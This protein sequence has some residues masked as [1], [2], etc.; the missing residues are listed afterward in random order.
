M[1]EHPDG[2]WGQVADM[3]SQQIGDLFLKVFLRQGA[4]KEASNSRG[5]F[6]VG[7]NLLEKGRPFAVKIPQLFHCQQLQDAHSFT[8]VFVILID[9]ILA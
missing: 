2:G 4:S 7:G 5:D 1:P 9:G 3:L 6:L 8:H